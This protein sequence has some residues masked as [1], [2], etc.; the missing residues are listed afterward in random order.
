MNSDF[1]IGKRSI[2]AEMHAKR[3]GFDK[4]VFIKEISSPNDAI[5]DRNRDAILIKTESADAMRRMIDKTYNFCKTI[6][7]LGTD[8]KISRIALEN[9][10]VSGLV[11]P[12]HERK[13]DYMDRRN[14]GLNQVLCKIARDNKKEIIIDFR[15]ILSKEKEER[16][17]LL[18][19]IAQNIALCRKYG[20]RIRIANFASSIGEMRSSGEL[21]SLCA[22]IGMSTAQI[23]DAL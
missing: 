21:R 5:K 17:I 1:F 12:E 15:S 14:S 3:E 9:R 8:D 20:V 2:E 22:A 10:K 19:R 4:I 16:A 6:L 18:G 13:N 11:S 7:V 23:R